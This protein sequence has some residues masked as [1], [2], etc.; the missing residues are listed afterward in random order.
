MGERK[1]KKT[2]LQSGR[3]ANHKRPLDTENKLRVDEGGGEG[4]MGDGQ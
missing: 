2:M 3:E 1:G 4:K